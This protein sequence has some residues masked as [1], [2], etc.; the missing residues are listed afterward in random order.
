MI[1]DLIIEHIYKIKI[2]PYLRIV[3]ILFISF[4][5]LAQNT[6][7]KIID[8]ENS[9]EI[10]Y[11]QIENIDLGFSEITND[12]GEF[13]INKPG[14]YTFSKNGY[15]SKTLSISSEEFII[16]NLEI[17]SEILNEVLLISSNLTTDLKTF[18]GSVSL[19]STKEITR[20]NTIN[21]A[22]ILNSVAGV[23]MH[24]G[25]LNT[26]R[27]TIRGI[28][29]R[30]LFGTS[31]IRAYYQ[32]IPLTNGSG[33]STIEDIELNAL[34]RI[35][36]LKGPSSS[37]Y[38]AGLG[39][40]IQL[41]PNKGNFDETSINSAF[42]FGSFGLQKFMTQVNI[43]NLTNS[44]NLVYSN[45][46]SDGYRENNKLNR[47]VISLSSN[48]FLSDKDR[49]TLIGNFIK[50]KAFIP[51]SLNEEDYLNNPESAA[52]TWGRSEGFED[53][54][55]GLFGVSWEHKYN[56]RTKQITSVFTSFLDSYEPRPF[57]VLK[58]NTIAI[59]LRSRILSATKLFKK[60]FKWTLGG[61]IFSDKNDL[62][63]FENLYQEF[64]PGTG[65]V[66][67]EK[68]SDFK[69]NRI[70]FNIFLDSKYYISQKL[71][72]NFG[73]NFNQTSYKLKD[74]FTDNDIDF[75]GNYNFDI[76]LSPKIGLTYQINDRS[77]IYG[78]I[79]H[80][81]SPPSLEETLLP[82]GLINT[83]IKPETGW[84]YE[85]GSRGNLINNIFAYDIAFY[86]MN[87]NDLLV[88][89]RSSDDEFIGVN[90]G[91]TRYNGIE[92]TL[93][94][95]LIN[96]KAIKLSHLN[97]VAYNDF[98]FREF[99]Y[100][101]ND[102]SGNQLTG[103]PEFTFNSRFN[104]Q[105]SLGFYGLLTYNYV[106]EIP[107]RDDNTVYSDSYQLVHTKVGYRS[108]EIKKFQFD[109]FI[110]VNNLFNEKYASM[111][112]INAGSFGGNAPRYY[113][114]GE[115]INYYSGLN[116]KYTF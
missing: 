18:N 35:E 80:G 58:E 110:G 2:L 31:K 9:L 12:V 23:Y 11:V 72:F 53:Y 102:Y 57:N 54:D 79:S 40:T 82:D 30:N 46:Q 116:L 52:F 26:N 81:F 74:K 4:P 38:G 1:I 10:P 25:T 34:G 70:Y 96:S 84:N 5:L 67:G 86:Q 33:E 76:I 111:L 29:S 71:V 106:S 113:Y 114:P 3:F 47:Q 103:V 59:G 39:G 68:L 64:P 41:I 62:Q 99:V 65:S 95:N 14:K 63:T 7:I 97:S 69:E 17:K 6:K 48:H 27:I 32:D 44:A 45:T 13:Q 24:N 49:F 89:R 60:A 104:I 107:I 85:I 91:K 101:E 66:E 16:I 87:V 61:E 28:G 51:S 20:N 83:N 92:L 37:V 88:A 98:K 50:L 75:S 55:K 94:Y 115:P 43:G 108:G 36:I 100:L 105:S 73:M 90:A 21:I 93:N 8:S 78:T 77:M 15:T 42:L 19:I 56:V 109:L 112:L 22:P